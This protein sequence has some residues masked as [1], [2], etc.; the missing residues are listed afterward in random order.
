[1]RDLDS[2]LYSL[3]LSA[4]EYVYFD[5]TK[6]TGATPSSSNLGNADL[7]STDAARTFNLITNTNSNYLEITDGFKR[8]F[9]IHGDGAHE[10][11]V[12]NSSDAFKIY[13]EKTSTPN[14]FVSFMRNSGGFSSQI[15][16]NAKHGGANYAAIEF[17]ANSGAYIRSLNFVEFKQGYHPFDTIFGVD[18]TNSEIDLYGDERLQGAGA[19]K[20]ILGGALSTDYFSVRNSADTADFFKVNGVGD[21]W[22]NGKGNGSTNTAFGEG[23]FNASTTGLRNTAYGYNAGTSLTSATDSVIMGWS[24]GDA[25]TTGLSNTLIG[26]AAGSSLSTQSYNVMVGDGA[27]E[28][29]TTANSIYIGF[30]AGKGCNGNNNVAVGYQALDNTASTAQLCVAVGNN[31]L[32]RAT[33]SIYSIAIGYDAGSDITTG[34]RNT[35]IGWDA[36]AG[37]TTGGFNTILGNVTGLSSSL[38]N[39]VILADGSGNEAITKDNN[40]NVWLGDASA[41]ATTATDGFNYVRGGAGVPTGTPATSV[42]GHVPMYVD[43]TNNKMYIYSG[44]SWVALN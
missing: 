42:T 11:D 20:K 39:H 17:E 10:M 19:H 15:T 1:M 43:T 6:F 38:A 13:R 24:A 14:N 44:G 34:N 7:T 21:V 29:S 22:A 37:I 18:Y 30:E 40:G 25:I 33:S 28:N 8:M 16:L 26:S 31:A 3:G 5:G 12:A 4:G 32:T 35:L 9:S 23:V 2:E 36:G 27:G 41:L